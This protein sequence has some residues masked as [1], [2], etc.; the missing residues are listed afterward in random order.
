MHRI[1][2]LLIV[3]IIIPIVSCVTDQDIKSSSSVKNND[4]KEYVVKPIIQPVASNGISYRYIFARIEPISSEYRMDRKTESLWFRGAYLYLRPDG[5]LGLN[6][7]RPGSYAYD[8]A[9]NWVMEGDKLTLIV[10][11]GASYS[12]DVSIYSY[13]MIAMTNTNKG[14]TNKGKKFKMTAFRKEKNEK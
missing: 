3:F 5:M 7:S 14:K 11:N 1:G 13:P 10:G 12:F 6:W 2:I 8:P 4:S 9:F